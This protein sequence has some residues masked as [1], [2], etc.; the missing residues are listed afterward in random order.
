MPKKPVARP[1]GTITVAAGVNGA[2]KSTIIGQYLKLQGAGY[3][4][5][6]ERTEALRAAGKAAGDA[7]EQ[8]WNEGFAA[9]GRAIDE[10]K[11]W[12]FETTLGGAS[13]TSE[14]LRALAKGRG[15]TIYYVG[16]D[17]VE[18]HLQRVAARVARGGHDIP[19]AKIRERCTTSLAN[20]MKFIGTRASIRVWDNS[21][22]DA[23]GIPC[24]VDVL[25]IEAGRL[26]YP[27]N[28]AELAATPAW[29]RGLVQHAMEQCA[30]APPLK[31][32]LL[33]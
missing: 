22:E 24:P 19:E 28:V 2:G 18:R 29:A 32:A 5:P 15:V 26:L 9:L 3:Y 8:A 30:V 13:V 17:R 10:G 16:L 7:N 27:A 20:L 23:D 11:A 4:N 1:A 25:A 21:E 14:L 6:D 33:R 12:T 31:R